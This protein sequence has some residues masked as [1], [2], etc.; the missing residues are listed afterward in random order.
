MS[1]AAGCKGRTLKLDRS[2][3]E[4]QHRLG[5]LLASDRSNG[6]NLLPAYKWLVLAQSSAQ[7]SASMAQEIRKL[8]TPR[9]NRRGRT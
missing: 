3:T 2:N 4:A 6:T 1:K 7:E 8:L 9:A 5:R